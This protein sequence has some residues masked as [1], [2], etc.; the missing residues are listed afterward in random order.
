MSAI[1]DKLPSGWRWESLAE[2]AADGAPIL[3]G[4]LQPGPDMPGG[5]PYVRPTEIVEDVIDLS[6]I[7]RTTPAIAGKYKRSVLKPD[8]VILSIVGTI[9]KVAV[10]PP[11]LDGGNITQSSVRVRP[12]SEVVSPRYVAWVLRSPVL[13]RQFDKHRLGTAVPRLNVAHVRALRVPV[14]PLPEQRRIVAEIEKQFTRLEAGVAALRRVQA[15]LKR[16]RAA[17]LKA[18]CEGRLV[19]TEA[20]LVGRVPPR[21]GRVKAKGNAA[22]GDAA[23]NNAP[24]ET[25]AELLARILT[26]RRQ[27][28]LGRGKYKEPAAPETVKLPELPT[29]WTWATV[30]QL[31]APEPNSITDGPFGSNLKTEH[32]MDSG[33][34]VI[35][36]QNIGDGVY[37]DEEAHIAQAHFERLQKHRIFAGDLVIAGF[38]ENPPRSCIIPETLGPAI[39]KADCIRFKPHG[40][41]LPKYMN[42]ALNSDPVRKRTK[43]MVHGVGRPR[44]NLGEIKSI[45]LPLP[46]PAEQT[47]IVAEVERRLSVVEEL[48]SVVTANLQRATRLRQSILQKAFTGELV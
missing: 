33:P 2:V 3:Y 45:A 46:P 19:P 15:N 48:E 1:D 10:V 27:N 17:V 11:D 6:S 38:G 36:L 7:R 21:G 12:R 24:F 29:G 43:G 25:G 41:V 20:E 18:A 30:E 35:R 16:Y 40:S 37:V 13:R 32:Y 31:A 47:R 5:V 23:Y 44:L 8:D 42:V 4:I 22:S 28:W 9:G 34:R 39:V 26:E 14:P